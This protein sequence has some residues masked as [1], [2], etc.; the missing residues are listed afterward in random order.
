MTYTIL[1]NLEPDTFEWHEARRTSL[2]ASEVAAV[3]GLSKW[4]TPLGVYRTK[5]G[6]PNEIPEDLAY[7]GHKMEPLIAQWIIDKH[8]EVRN[9]EDGFSARSH[10]FPWLTASPDRTAVDWDGRDTS[11]A[12]LIPVE[13]KNS[14]AYGYDDWADEFGNRRPPLYYQAQSQTQIAVMGAPYGWLAVLHGG[15]TPELFRIER[16]DQFIEMLTRITGEWWTTHV[17]AQ[18]PPEPT[19]LGELAEVFPS[20]PSTEIEASETALEVAERRAVLLADIRDQQAEADALTLAVGQYMGEAE[21]LT[22]KGRPVV[23]YKTQAG[24]RTADLAAI[25]R[26]YPEIAPYVIKTGNPF[27]VMRWVRKDTDE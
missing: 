21:T 27:K 16:D 13:L 25:T 12:I 7:F 10:E 17:V 8:P 18:L 15:N 5:M 26:D 9:L 4:Q 20:I 2:G 1:P 6:V 14:S 11:P 23:T 19:T 24:K 3:L 22:Y